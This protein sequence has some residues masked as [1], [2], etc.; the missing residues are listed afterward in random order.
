MHITEDK[1]RKRLP[2]KEYIGQAIQKN[3]KIRIALLGDAGSGKSVAMGLIA[4]EV[5]DVPREQILVPIL[6]TFS[7]IKMVRDSEAFE[8]IIVRNLEKHQFEHGKRTKNAEEYVHTELYDGNLLLLLDGFD[9]LNKNTRFEITHF[10]NEFFAKYPGIPFVLSSRTSVWNQNPNSFEPLNLKIVTTADFTPLEI[11]QFVAQWNFTAP[12]SGEQLADL[13]SE[14]IYLKTIAVNPL[15]LTIISFLYAQPKRILP[16]NRVKFYKECIE[17]LLEKWDYAKSLDRAN[18]F[19]T[20]DKVTILSR[21]AHHHISDFETTDEEIKKNEV[22][23]IIGETMKELSRPVAKRQKMLDEIAQNAEL[24][25]ELPPDGFKF[26]HRTFMEY[27]AAVYFEEKKLHDE[28]IN[29]YQADKGKWQETMALFCGLN[30]NSDTSLQILTQLLDNFQS[31]IYSEEEPDTFVFR[32]LVESAR[33]NESLAKEIL[34]TGEEYLHT[35]LNQE[36]IENLGYIAVNPNWEHRKEA[37]E[38]LLRQLKKDLQ[39][40]ELQRVILA[41]VNIN[42]VDIRSTIMKHAESLNLV[43]FVGNLGPETE[44]Y[45]IKLMENMSEEK[46]EGLFT[47][48]KQG[49]ALKLLAQIMFRSKKANLREQAAFVLASTSMSLEFKDFLDNLDVRN[50]RP[51]HLKMTNEKILEFKWNNTCPKTENGKKALTLICYFSANY[52]ANKRFNLYIDSINFW[53]KNTIGLFLYEMGLHST[54]II[55]FNSPITVSKKGF[56]CCQSIDKDSTKFISERDIIAYTFITMVITNFALLIYD[57]S[58][59]SQ[60]VFSIMCLALFIAAFTINQLENS[61]RN[62]TIDNLAKFIIVLIF[63]PYTIIS[64]YFHYQG[65]YTDFFYHRKYF[66]LFFCLVFI[67]SFFALDFSIIFKIYQQYHCLTFFN[68]F[69]FLHYT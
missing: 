8:K 69:F 11:R 55:L 65:Y 46:L 16:D 45:A 42:D 57:R 36:I 24:L 61:T 12:K 5:W 35:E 26:P 63:A 67:Y 9:E 58:S 54:A 37:K 62:I 25:I 47:G 43:E 10:L 28:L 27:F 39:P 29:E 22:L 19:E 66:I 33:V 51:E 34:K 50:I 60:L 21:I 53:C 15:M 32:A 59:T 3:E 18:E 68:C 40:E 44:K 30:T 20:I 23:D 52:F 6:L 64:P 31:S 7:D 48:L 13:I 56:I 38:I 1:Q 2:L 4:R 49:G 41:L 17:A 14:K